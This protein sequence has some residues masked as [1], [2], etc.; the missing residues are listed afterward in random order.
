MLDAPHTSGRLLRELSA[1]MSLRTPQEQSLTVLSEVLDLVRPGK[2]TDVVAALA[3]IKGRYPE[4]TDFERDFVSLCFALATGVGK[5]RLMGAFM[6]YLALTGASRNFFVLAPNTTI[7]QKLVTD[8]TPGTPKYVFKGVAE[9]VTKPPVIVTGDTWDQSSIFIDGAQRNGGVIINVFNVDKINKDVGRIRKLNEYIGQSYFDHLAA[10]PDLVLLMDEAHRY[11]AKAAFKAIADLRPILGLELSATPKT[12]GTR[13]MDFKN[14]IYRFGLREA[15]DSGYVKEPAVATR[16]NFRPQDYEVEHLERIKLEDGVHA[17]TQVKVELEMFHRDTGQRLV[18]PFMLVVA[19]DTTHAQKLKEF[20]ESDEFFAGYYNDKVIRVDSGTST[21]ETDDAT[22]RLL[23]LETDDRTEIVIHVN[24]LKEGWD[25]TNLFTIVPLR[26]SASDILTEQTLGRGLRLPYGQRTGVEAIDRLTIIAHDRF[27]EV[28]KAAQAPDSLI[29][30]KAIRIGGD[31]EVPAGNVELVVAP[32]KVEASLTGKGMAEGQVPFMFSTPE[33]Q[34]VATA[35]LDVIGRMGRH[36]R[37][38]EDLAKPEIQAQIAEQVKQMTRPA[39]AQLPGVGAPVPNVADIIA[40]VI[41]QVADGTI[42]I[43]EIVVI[44]DSAVSFTFRDFDLQKL[45]S[46]AFRPLEKEIVVQ[47]LRTQ[48]RSI[49]S[50]RTGGVREDRL[51]DYVVAE[52]ILVPEVDYDAH[53][54]LLYKLAGQ[55]VARLRSYLADDDEV[56]QVLI[57]QRKRI[58]DFISQQMMEHYVEMATTYRVNVQTGFQGLKAQNFSLSVGQLP[59]DFRTP[60]TPK[61][62][63]RKHV[64]SGFNR[65]CYLLQAF[66]SDSERQFAVIVDSDASVVRWVK[67]GRGQFAIWYSRGNRYEPDFVIETLTEKLVCEVKAK[68]ELT[69]EDV[70]AKAKA[71]RV[72]VG[73]ANDHAAS[74]AK[75]PW[76]YILIP[77]DALTGGATLGG[78]VATYEQGPLAPDAPKAEAA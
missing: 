15:L 73:R 5:T 60:V 21:E 37:T 78:L 33:E 41:Q 45:E 1:R 76:R 38:A 59:Q 48:A 40:T 11:R 32:S 67:P 46:I 30:M 54:D 20:V 18:H 74:A 12:V 43:P 36:L 77:D 9:F 3:A 50:V 7:Y 16:A 49:I 34:N 27:D 68:N 25:V 14:V 72:W 53:S 47:Q 69:S 61:S 52:L 63:T 19:Q 75:K 71:A 44:P 62:D 6:A 64:F 29:Q 24:K 13:P 42:E 70:V 51:E 28:I 65:C 8:L 58:A 55:V 26:A 35:T 2:G 10:Q 39:Q 17:H 57:T 31:G 4:V 56:E 22:Q 66:D 23:A